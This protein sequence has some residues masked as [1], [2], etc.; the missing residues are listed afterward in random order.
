[1]QDA[2]PSVIIAMLLNRSQTHL[3]VDMTHAR[4]S[5]CQRLTLS[6]DDLIK[7][8]E[9]HTTTSSYSGQRVATE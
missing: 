1:M 8:S 7:P 4:L 3:I 2:L 5:A 9:L 6:K